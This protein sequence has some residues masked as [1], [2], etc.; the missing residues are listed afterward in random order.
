M[1]YRAG[2][3]PANEQKILREEIFVARASIKEQAANLQPYIDSLVEKRLK[4]ANLSTTDQAEIRRQATETVRAQAQIV[5]PGYPRRWVIDLSSLP[6]DV[7]TQPLQ[8]RVNDLYQSRRHPN[9][10]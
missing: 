3:L 10:L 2:H 6:A 5:P 4:G 1:Q 7:R 8:A 9:T